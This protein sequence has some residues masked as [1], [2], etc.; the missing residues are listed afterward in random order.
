MERLFCNEKHR[1]AY[2]IMLYYIIYKYHVDSYVFRQMLSIWSNKIFITLLWY[3]YSMA[4]K[5]KLLI[6]SI[7]PTNLTGMQLSCMLCIQTD[8]L[9]WR[10]VM[11]TMH[12]MIVP[13]LIRCNCTIR[14]QTDLSV[15]S[16]MFCT[17]FGSKISTNPL[18]LAN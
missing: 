9:L 11:Y 18:G 10:Y 8:V 3:A 12:A 6:I 14:Y 1:I 16:Q 2:Y 5:N 4:K 17:L 13:Y 15:F 7:I